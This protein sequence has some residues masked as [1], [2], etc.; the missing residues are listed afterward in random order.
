MP[1]VNAQAPQAQATPS[2]PALGSYAN[3]FP[4]AQSI[5]ANALTALP[6]QANAAATPATPATPSASSAPAQ[7]SNNAP[8]APNTSA[9]SQ[10][11]AQ[12]QAAQTPTQ[13]IVNVPNIGTLPETSPAAQA[14][15]GLQKLA[16]DYS[17][18]M[19]ADKS[20]AAKDRSTLQQQVNTNL[21]GASNQIMALKHLSNAFS[22]M[23]NQAIP[24]GPLNKYLNS[25]DIALIGQIIGEPL[26]GNQ[27]VSAAARGLVEKLGNGI[28]NLR[29]YAGIKELVIGAKPSENDTLATQQD[30]L[31]YYADLMGRTQDKNLLLQQGLDMNLP[32]NKIES[33]INKEFAVKPEDSYD[34]WTN[35]RANI[36]NTQVSRVPAP[37]SNA[38]KTTLDQMQGLSPELKQ[39]YQTLIQRAKSGDAEAA[40]ALDNDFKIA[41]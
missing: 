24:A 28:S 38:G 8:V 11:S 13:K 35:R 23:N 32:A 33:V 21:E 26:D 17:G 36:T 2:V 25:D 27:Q 12:D 37:V 30:K 5:G 41:Y 10:V 34:K 3:A 20:Q 16:P 6:T 15:E 7:V 40:R 18:V 4:Q 39:S 14:Y 22:A 1:L 29:A 9:A 31:N 19:Y